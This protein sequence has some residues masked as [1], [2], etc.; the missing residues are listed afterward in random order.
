MA[1]PGDIDAIRTGQTHLLKQLAVWHRKTVFGAPSHSPLPA[2]LLI[3]NQKFSDAVW[4][5]FC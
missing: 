3:F 4:P 1:A 5:V 2:I